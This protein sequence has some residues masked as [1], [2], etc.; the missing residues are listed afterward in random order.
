MSLSTCNGSPCHLQ[1]FTLPPTTVRPATCNGSPCHLQRFALPPATVRPA[2]C[3]GSPFHLR[4]YAV[5]PAT[6]LC[7]H[8]QRQTG[9][10]TLKP[11]YKAVAAVVRRRETLPG[12]CAPPR[13][14]RGRGPP[15]TS[16]ARSKGRRIRWEGPEG[17]MGAMGAKRPGLPCDR[18]PP[19]GSPSSAQ[20]L[21]K[22]AH[23]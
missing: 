10:A 16:P 11:Q 21:L 5:L 1:R 14:G 6:L 3:N 8:L 4:R 18:S 2:T 23:K 17:A 15:E 19:G 22:P 20:P 13:K 7:F 9:R 12:G